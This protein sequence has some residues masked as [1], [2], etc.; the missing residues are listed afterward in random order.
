MKKHLL[1]IIVAT[2]ALPGVELGAARRNAKKTAK[3]TA[4]AANQTASPEAARV[5]I[6]LYQDKTGTKNFEY[7]PGSLKEAITAS[8]HQ[9]FEFTEVDSSKVDPVVEQIRAKSK[10]TIG[11][12]EAAEI[13]RKADVDILIYGDFSYNKEAE[14]IEIHT[15]ISLGSTDKFRLLPAVEN[16]VDSTIFQAAD[17]VATDIVAEI[18]KVALE[19]Q[20][21]KGKA[22]LD[23]KGK[24]QLD[25]TEKSKTWQ[26]IN[27]SFALSAG[28]MYPLVNR[29]AADVKT[30]PAASLY[31]HYRL[32]NA[33]HIG[34]FTSFSGLRSY[35]KNSPYQTNFDHLSGAATVGYFFDLSPR[36]RWTNFVGAGYYYGRLSVSTECSSQNT[37]CSTGS[38][39]PISQDAK[40]P[41]F[42]ART[43]IHFLIFSWLAIGADAEYRMYYDS[44]PINTVGAALAITG[45]F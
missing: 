16:R 35:G 32:K 18:T 22:E 42:M 2:F 11:A 7:M 19:Q 17:K 5:A 30:E 38:F 21:A 27:W 1:Y 12:K 34:A 36:W 23:K 8:M 29:D 45:M 10:G 33:W 20:Q 24:T 4:A 14:E 9:K 6:L 25:K 26:D 28:P 13:C 15:N 31:G 39:Q 3:E 40:N 43:G 41:F 37:Q 44:K